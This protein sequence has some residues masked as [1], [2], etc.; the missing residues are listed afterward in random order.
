MASIRF[1]LK[2]PNKSSSIILY[3]VSF[4]NESGKWCQL[5]K[6]TKE[7]IPSEKWSISKQR[8]KASFEHAET[9]N[10]LLD[11]L[12]KKIKRISTECKRIGGTL[13]KEELEIYI[14][15]PEQ[16]NFPDE[17]KEPDLYHYFREYINHIKATHPDTKTYLQHDRT[18]I[19]IRE[20]EAKFNVRLDFEGFDQKFYDKFLRFLFNY[21]IKNLEDG[22][23]K[24]MG[25]GNAGKHIKN[26]KAFLTY[27]L[28]RKYHR[29]IEFKE[30]K[31]LR[32]EP[33][34]IPITEDELITLLSLNDLPKT[35]SRARDIFCFACF[36]G[37]RISDIQR[38]KPANIHWNESDLYPFGFLKLNIK[39][40][41]TTD[42]ILP[43]IPQTRKILEA[44]KG[45]P[46]KALPSLSDQ[47]INDK[48]KEVA[49]AAGLDREVIKTDTSG[50]QRVEKVY[51]LHQ[52]ISMHTGKRTLVTRL[53]EEGEDLTNIA[54]I[55]GNTMKTIGRYVKPDPRRKV[56]ALLKLNKGQQ[57]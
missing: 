40:N 6:S 35:K 29:N 26:L 45:N 37:L 31:V 13:S 14:D 55:T 52:V 54:I 41:K 47:K 8:V 11:K 39:K 27:C 2:E 19:L 24:L 30:F 34:I 21:P 4:K 23:I 53:H 17:A 49:K 57:N 28:K 43:L 1:F 36:T 16:V 15:Q 9:I 33:E 12:E 51:K 18:F 50:G 5:M 46:L 42:H 44:Y 20:F 48:I 38:L 22:S 10:T 25:V 3:R 32:F 7:K 56:S